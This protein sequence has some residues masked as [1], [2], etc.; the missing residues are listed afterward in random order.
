MK[1]SWWKV[2]IPA[3]W[4]SIWLWL[5]NEG[6]WEFNTGEYARGFSITGT[7]VGDPVAQQR[8]VDIFGLVSAI[9]KIQ[10]ERTSGL[11]DYLC[12]LFFL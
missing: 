4:A 2:V 7:K 10:D 1:K 9:L 8:F 11:H 3:L 6:K 5:W 12:L